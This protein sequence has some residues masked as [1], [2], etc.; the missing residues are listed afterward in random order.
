M[1]NRTTM[2]TPTPRAMSPQDIVRIYVPPAPPDEQQL[3]NKFNSNATKETQ[4]TS[5]PLATAGPDS[6]RRSPPK[7]AFNAKDPVTGGEQRALAPGT[8]DS[9]NKISIT[10][11][12]GDLTPIHYYG[13][14]P[15]WDEELMRSI[16]ESASGCLS[17]ASGGH[18]STSSSRRGSLSRKS[19][20]SMFE[21]NLVME[22]SH[23]AAKRRLSIQSNN[24]G[25]LILGS[26]E[27][28]S[29]LEQPSSLSYQ[30]RNSLSNG[31]KVMTS[32]EQ[33]AALRCKPPDE[34]AEEL[35]RRPV[36][37]SYSPDDDDSYC[38]SYYNSYKLVESRQ[39]KS[40]L[41]VNRA[42][43]FGSESNIQYA[44]QISSDSPKRRPYSCSTETS[45]FQNDLIGVAAISKATSIKEYKRFYGTSIDDDDNEENQGVS[46]DEERKKSSDDSSSSP[47]A[48]TPVNDTIPLLAA[49]PPTTTVFGS[50]AESS[51]SGH[52]RH[53]VKVKPHVTIAQTPIVRPSRIPLLQNNQVMTASTSPVQHSSSSSPMQ[54]PNDLNC[55]M[56]PIEVVG[57]R[58]SSA[59]RS[60]LTSPSGS[61]SE[62]GDFSDGGG[63][64]G[65]ITSN[66][67]RVIAVQ[68]NN[69][70]TIRIK[71]NDRN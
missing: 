53:Q 45:A 27:N 42:K 48:E 70:N 32:F 30:R 64:N 12:S 33:L 22:C 4:P 40:P 2:L 55:V 52:I 17:N 37:V 58:Y 46:N 15:S 14:Q 50:I 47:A 63:G 23:M 44:T 1:V 6:H 43:R 29:D 65:S 51:L 34:S 39:R 7:D 59:V 20:S 57:R 67:D 38:Y 13:M 26:S 66:G 36:S 60:K 28:I 56:A 19:P 5:L 9:N 69:T 24:S 61:S 35:P 62:R 31:G 8:Y 68:P 11:G 49:S 25:R 3:I 10:N 16:N 71:V 54:S 18:R 41:V 21:S